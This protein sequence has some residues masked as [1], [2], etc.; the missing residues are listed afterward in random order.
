M[1]LQPQNMICYGL[2]F[3]YGE[4]G[5]DG[6][7]IQQQSIIN[8][9][10]PRPQFLDKFSWGNPHAPD[11][12]RN[13][14]RPELFLLDPKIIEFLRTDASAQEILEREVQQLAADREV[15]YDVLKAVEKVEKFPKIPLPLHLD[16]MIL[17][18][19][20]EFG[21][22]DRTTSDLSPVY[23]VKQLKALMNRLI[24]VPG[25][26][27]LSMEAQENATL[28]MGIQL[29]AYLAS[30][31]AIMEHHL[32]R[33]AFDLLLDHI[34][35]KFMG[36]K[37]GGETCFYAVYSA[38]TRVTG[39]CW[40]DVWC[41]CCSEHWRTHYPDD[42]EHFPLCWCFCK[43]CYIGCAPFE[44]IDQCGKERC[45]SKF[46][47]LDARPRRSLRKRNSRTATAT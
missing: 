37:V 12:G 20:T 5:I 16:R 1:H 27:R 30:K 35:E 46:N 2:Q 6:R 34:Y 18:I 22:T 33:D 11:F 41:P 17:N 42:T 32:T 23:V 24:V 38:L 7:W 4:D 31:V 19:K 28:L 44:G 13:P 3:L 26:D 25:D 10:L 45:H 8:F 43:E 14:R 21:L 9:G 36:A 39:G 40:R 29:R 15:L 47:H